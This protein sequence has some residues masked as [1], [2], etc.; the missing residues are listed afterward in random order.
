M[1]GLGT[2]RDSRLPLPVLIRVSQQQL[3]D[4]FVYSDIYAP[5]VPVV[6]VIDANLPNN[7]KRTMGRRAWERVIA[8]F[9]LR[10]AHS[11]HD[12]FAARNALAKLHGLQLSLLS[13]KIKYDQSAQFSIA[14]EFGKA[15]SS[16]RV[17][18]WWNLKADRLEPGIL[19]RDLKAALF[20][21]AALGDLRVCPCC[22]QP[23]LPDRPDQQYCSIL[24]RE[25]FRK[26]RLRARIK[27]G[28]K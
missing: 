13:P 20:L 24:C 19:C 1:P 25:R 21:R 27:R 12:D 28:G 14:A 16:A 22:D 4:G 2:S 10:A 9:L 17:I 11:N 15:M 8:T 18:L 23:F 7:V 6:R 3:A 5:G 26:R